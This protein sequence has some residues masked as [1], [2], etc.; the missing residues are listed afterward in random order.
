M[1]PPDAPVPEAE[2]ETAPEPQ[3]NPQLGA[4]VFRSSCAG[5]H[6]SRDGLDL[7]TFAYG[8]ATVMR[9]ALGH[10]DSTSARDILAHLRGLEVP[11]APAGHAALTPV[12]RLFQPGGRVL[13]DDLAFGLELFGEDAWPEGWSTDGLRALDPRDVP[14]ALPLPLWSDENSN[15]DWMPDAEVPDAVLDA[16]DGRAR[17]HLEDY[18]RRG[19]EES[20]REAV[21]AIRVADRYVTGAPCSKVEAPR[22][23]VCFDVRRWTATLTAQE[24]L[25]RGRAGQGAESDLPR[26]MTEPWWEVGQVSRRVM[27]AADSA[28]GAGTAVDNA[29]ENWLRWM[30]LGWIFDP[31][32]EPSP[33]LA[34]G[35]VRTGYPRHAVFT[36]L[37]TLV[38][39]QPGDLLA[40]HDA[41]TVG[42]YAPAAWTAASLGFAFR[43]LGERL[44][45]GESLPLEDVAEARSVVRAALDLAR[46]R[47]APSA[48]VELTALRD[49][50]LDGLNR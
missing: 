27:N 19:S 10:V 49:E 14:I 16:N 31:G 46:E 37:R 42:R 43:H 36:T 40:Y 24:M 30:Y 9:R 23:D 4:L 35:L 45:A 18:H 41:R 32:R 50:V 26:W 25:R 17:R 38:S 34:R 3:G 11:P 7:A 12:T 48:L 8:D 44:E 5:C 20:L 47:L 29:M 1:A 15:L 33:Y 2:P 22:Y 13:A 6:T 39:R 28:R 21:A